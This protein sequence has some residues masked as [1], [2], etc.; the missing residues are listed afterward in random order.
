MNLVDTATAIHATTPLHINIMYKDNCVAEL[1][2]RTGEVRIFQEHLMPYALWFDCSGDLDARVQNL[3]NFDTWCASRLLTMR[4][5]Y[6]K[7]IV[8]ACG[9]TQASTDKQRAE[10]A[11]QCRCLSVQDPY[12]ITGDGDS[13]SWKQVC[14]FDNKSDNAFIDVCLRGKNM[15]VFE[16]SPVISNLTVDGSMSKAWRRVGQSFCLLKSGSYEQTEKEVKASLVLQELGL[17]V[18]AYTSAAYGEQ[19]I[20]M[21]DAFTTRDVGFVT[22][23]E[24][25]YNNELSEVIARYPRQFD[26][27]VLSEYII[28]N[29]DLH[30]RNWGFLFEDGSIIG[31]APLFDFDHAFELDLTQED[32]D[33]KVWRFVGARKNLKFA[34]KSACRNLGLIRN[35]FS[36]IR[37]EYT[38]EAVNRLFS[39]G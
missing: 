36:R 25:S 1:D 4:R 18:V 27:L 10:V 38:T 39:E 21:C 14:L 2:R 24:Y 20:T 22:A 5:T 19:P 26:Q 28:G 29:S 11:I 31:M 33:S 3:Y 8:N 37:C 35:S 23:E 7:E 6:Y 15:S 30:A 34:A 12:W 9:F 13:V 17:N 16:L 32:T